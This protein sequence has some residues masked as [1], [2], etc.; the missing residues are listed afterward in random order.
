MKTLSVAIPFFNRSN[1]I[2]QTLNNILEDTRV[3]EIIIQDDFSRDDDFNFLIDKFSRVKKIKI[4][5]NGKNLGAYFNKLEAV[6]SC[7]NEW[8]ILLDSDNYLFKSYIDSVFRETEWDKEYCYIPDEMLANGNREPW[9]RCEGCWDHGR[10]GRE[11][12]G[13]NDIK[14]IWENDYGIEGLLNAGNYFFNKDNYILRANYILKEKDPLF[15]N[16]YASDCLALMYYWLRDGGKIKILENA[17]YYHRMHDGS[18]WKELSEKSSIYSG[19][20][21]DKFKKEV[22]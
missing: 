10:F 7:S 20:I 2:E 15:S 17:E 18:L 11:P 16:P 19:V 3:S 13:F 21:M 14:K 5:R 1:L 6:K 9:G 8:V 4:R 12:I 22:I